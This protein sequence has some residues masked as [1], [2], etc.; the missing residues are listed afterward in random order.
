MPKYNAWDVLWIMT[1]IAKTLFLWSMDITDSDHVDTLN[2]SPRSGGTDRLLCKS[3]RL[4]VPCNL[5]RATLDTWT[6][7][8]YPGKG[9]CALLPAG[10]SQH[11]SKVHRSGSTSGAASSS[12][13]SSWL[14][15]LHLRQKY[16]TCPPLD[17][18]Y[19]VHRQTSSCG[20]FDQP[21]SSHGI[22]LR[23][24]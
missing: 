5:C 19:A 16:T 6:N 24:C 14:P 23:L 21:L 9:S 2:L 22:K 3:A 7:S 1:V 20:S 18:A 11:R 10:S 13:S 8:V 12:H 4:G 17:I 15:L